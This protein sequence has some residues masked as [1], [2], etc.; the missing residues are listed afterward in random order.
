M[1]LGL[2]IDS[3]IHYHLAWVCYSL[4]LYGEDESCSFHSHS[5]RKEKMNLVFQVTDHGS[6]LSLKCLKY[7]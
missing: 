1:E 7:E 4:F 6:V 2:L 3:R 5:Q